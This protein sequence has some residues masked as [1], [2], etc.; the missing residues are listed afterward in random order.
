MGLK[1]LKRWEIGSDP[2]CGV[3]Y[4]WNKARCYFLRTP[5]GQVLVEVGQGYFS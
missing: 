1:W 5:V 2:V 4:I 3:G